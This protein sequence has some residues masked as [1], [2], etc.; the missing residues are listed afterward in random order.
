V[1]AAFAAVGPLVQAGGPGDDRITRVVYSNFS[2]APFPHHK[3]DPGHYGLSAD[4]PFG[5]VRASSGLRW[6]LIALAAFLVVATV[7]R[8]VWMFTTSAGADDSDVGPMP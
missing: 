8:F 7:R 3:A 1:L 4:T 5:S 2:H 6:T